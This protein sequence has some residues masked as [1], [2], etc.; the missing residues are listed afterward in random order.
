MA[1]SLESRWI[2]FSFPPPE[3]PRYFFSPCEIAGVDQELQVMA[4]VSVP[5]QLIGIR[6]GILPESDELFPQIP[7]WI[8]TSLFLPDVMG[9]IL[10]SHFL[11]IVTGN[12][13]AR[14]VEIKYWLSREGLINSGCM[15]SSNESLSGPTYCDTP[16]IS[17]SF[18]P[19][20]QL[21]L[22]N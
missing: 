14:F 15:Y 1:H 13:P 19:M 16:L 9:D 6:I 17:I 2:L 12:Q 4:A 21:C 10:I 11:H 5:S 7:G 8:I 18:T 20:Q 22:A 3:L